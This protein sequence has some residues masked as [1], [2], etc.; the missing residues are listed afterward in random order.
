MSNFD[1]SYSG[2]IRKNAQKEAGDNKPD[3]KGSINIGG[4]HHWLA[5]WVRKGDDG[6][7][8]LS[9]KAEPKED[10]QAAP[11]QQQRRQRDDSEDIPF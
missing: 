6:S 9:L 8:F 4:V 7:T 3:Y 1:N 11:K 5:G 10:K 2:T